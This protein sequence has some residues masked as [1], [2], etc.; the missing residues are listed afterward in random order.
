V[1]IRTVVS[2]C[3]NCWCSVT[4][5]YV[6][7]SFSHVFV[8]LSQ[9]INKLFCILYLLVVS[10]SQA[11]SVCRVLFV[12]DTVLLI[13]DVL[14]PVLCSGKAWRFWS[15]RG[16]RKTRRT[17]QL[18][19]NRMGGVIFQISNCFKFPPENLPEIYSNLS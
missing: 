6:L 8:R 10:L 9:V 3:C 18:S 17:E 15:M 4:A 14:T 1:Y 2:D 16:F 13:N 19:E 5:A 7:F 12:H 11:V